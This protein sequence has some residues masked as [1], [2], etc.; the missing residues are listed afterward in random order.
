MKKYLLLFFFLMLFCNSSCKKE[1]I[2]E[3]EAMQLNKKEALKKYG[4]PYAQEFFPTIE[5]YGE[6]RN[7][8]YFRYKELNRLDSITII[9]EITWEK[10]KDTLITVWYERKEK[11]AVPVETYTWLKGTDF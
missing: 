7:Y 2:S 3:K 5:A 8:V 4:N 9:D 6:F 10:T 11:E 1:I